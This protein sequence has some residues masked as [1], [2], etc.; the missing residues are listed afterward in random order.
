MTGSSFL[1]AM[2]VMS[3]QYQRLILFSIL[4]GDGLVAADHQG[5]H[6]RILVSPSPF[7]CG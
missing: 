5:L 3:L 4:I 7:N 1:P 2:A 6:R